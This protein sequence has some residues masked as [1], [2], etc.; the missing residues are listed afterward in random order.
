MLQVVSAIGDVLLEQSDPRWGLVYSKV[1]ACAGSDPDRMISEV[2]KKM[3][4]KELL[5][6]MLKK[7]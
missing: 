3:G 5:W 1:M 7:F 4:S 2:S 6:I